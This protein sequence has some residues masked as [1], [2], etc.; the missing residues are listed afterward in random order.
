MLIAKIIPLHSVT[1]IK[2]PATL[3]LQILFNQSD[4]TTLKKLASKA[5]FQKCSLDTAKFQSLVPKQIVIQKDD[6]A[7]ATTDYFDDLTMSP[8]RQQ[9]I[10][11]LQCRR[12]SYNEVQSVKFLYNMRQSR[13]HRRTVTQTSV[14]YKTRNTVN[15][16]KQYPKFQNIGISTV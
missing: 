8:Q 3:T 12:I 14:I 7:A 5:Q 15:R 16:L 11:P 9:W 6:A 4:G 10:F 2:L 13:N 1:L